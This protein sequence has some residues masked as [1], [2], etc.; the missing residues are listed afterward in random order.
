VLNAANEVAVEAF[1]D[2]RL[3]FLGIAGLIATTLD[4][5]PQAEVPDLASVLEADRQGR[6]AAL[7]VLAGMGATAA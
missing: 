2:R 3:P 7:D 1:L 4:Q 6:I 5:V